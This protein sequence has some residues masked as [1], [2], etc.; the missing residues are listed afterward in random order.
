MGREW[1]LSYRLGMRKDN[2]CYCLALNACPEE[3]PEAPLPEK[4]TTSGEGGPG[5]IPPESGEM[6]EK[7]RRRIIKGFALPISD[8]FL[9]IVEKRKQNGQNLYLEFMEKMKQKKQ[10]FISA[11][12]I[13]PNATNS[14]YLDTK[15]N[16]VLYLEKHRVFPGYQ[17]GTYEDENVVF[18][19]FPQHVMAHYLR[20]LQYGDLGDRFAVNQM[21]GQND[22]Q[23]REMASYAGSLGGRQQQQ[24]LRDQNRGWYNSEVQRKLG[25]KGAAAAQL[26][27]VGAF[28]PQN[29]FS[30]TAVWQKKYQ[31]DLAFKQKMLKNLAQGLK[32]QAQQGTNIFNPISQ[33]HRVINGKGILI[34]GKIVFSP[35]SIVYPDETFEYSEHR[36]HLSED[37]YWNHIK[38]RP[39][40]K[41]ANYRN[42]KPKKKS[43]RK[44][45][46][47]TCNETQNQFENVQR[48]EKTLS[49]RV[50]EF[51]FLFFKNFFMT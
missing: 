39:V 40:G 31:Q 32:T 49:L 21:L 6:L 9:T 4:K 1:E 14:D 3:L 26:K 12:D 10:N 43:S 23:R 42:Q 36:V 48:L 34:D 46:P 17:S 29:L 5:Q 47:L 44:N 13:V 7:R 18:L 30:A 2:L 45:E 27:G 15:K 20:F 16:V 38:N 35:Y 50:P 8:K 41:R 25:K 22:M 51:K 28:D 37:F 24:N 33:R 11:K 19:T